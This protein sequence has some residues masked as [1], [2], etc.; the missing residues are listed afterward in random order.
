MSTWITNMT[1]FPKPREISSR[2]PMAL[3]QTTLHFGSIVQMTA[4]LDAQDASAVNHACGG[5]LDAKL[6]IECDKIIWQCSNCADNGEISHW[7]ESGWEKL[8][9]DDMPRVV[10]VERKKKKPRKPKREKLGTLVLSKR[11]F[12]G[13][14][15]V[16]DDT[17]IMDALEGAHTDGK[18]FAVRMTINQ[19]DALS[20]IV[21]D[22]LDF[23]PSRQRK[24]WDEL[25]SAIGWVM[26]EISFAEIENKDR[27]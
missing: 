5:R 19:L 3:I 10:V 13:L 18:D 7:R 15:K 25:W 1:H 27:D 16:L 11:E 6:D 23:G 12:T 9:R 2:M 26:D 20:A 22:L 14:K 21:G 8:T 4:G 24:M 17:E